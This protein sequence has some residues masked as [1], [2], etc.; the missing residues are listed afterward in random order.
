MIKISGKIIKVV[1]SRYSPTGLHWKFIKQGIKAVVAMWI[2][3]AALD[4]IPALSGLSTVFLTSTSIMTA[5]IG[6]ASQQSI[7]NI[8]S[9]FMIS[10]FKPFSI[11]DKV[12]VR[13][14]KGVIE[15]INFRH[16]I[17]QTYENS[18]IIIPNSILNNEIL[19]NTNYG[20]SRICH[21]ID[22]YI[23]LESDTQVVK[24]LLTGIVSSHPLYLDVRTKEDIEKNVPKV[25][26]LL[27]SIDSGKIG[28]RISVWAIDVNT[29]Y[30]V[31][32]D[33]RESILKEF[34]K[35]HIKLI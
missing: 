31:C 3:Y 4:S 19:E 22:L 18:R 34:N 16:V 10:F 17:I 2:I 15:D 29:N 12:A 20:D 13:A 35:K 30:T 1:S 21:F 11:G 8:V 24:E 7:A 14:Y 28:L 32:S 25:Q 27:R 5:V 33:L 9:G 23:D 26:I 6:L